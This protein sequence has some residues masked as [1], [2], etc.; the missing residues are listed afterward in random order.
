[1][2][3]LTDQPPARTAPAARMGRALGV[4]L[5]AHIGGFLL[6]LAIVSRVPPDVTDTTT[7]NRPPP[8]IVWVAAPGPGGGGGGGGERRPEPP[9]SS[10]APGADA[11]T[12]RVTP[13]EPSREPAAPA[14]PAR[15]TIPAIETVAGLV[16]VPGVISPV[17][18]PGDSRGPGAGPGAGGGDGPGDGPGKGGGLGPGEDGNTGGGVYEPGSDISMPRLIHE[19]KPVYPA[20]ALRLRL[21]G[22]VFLEGIVL[23]DGSLDRIRITRSLDPTFG[24]DAEA[25]RTVKEWRFAPGRDRD[26][27]PVPVRVGIEMA[28]TLR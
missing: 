25:I 16:E 11:V 27:R 8:G 20:G 28:F 22:L 13:A 10:T 21:Q 6:I 9:R 23:P 3:L 4:S 7:S 2:P 12:V 17:A 15:L 5:A 24:L 19:T 26:G 18:N 14:P 1:M